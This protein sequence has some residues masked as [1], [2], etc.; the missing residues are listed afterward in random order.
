MSEQPYYIDLE[1]VRRAF[2]L[3]SDAPALLIDFASWLNGRPWGSVGCFGLLGQFS[4]QAPIVDGSL[5]RNDLALFLRLPEGCA[6]GTWNTT[7]VI[8]FTN[9][10]GT[11]R[12]G[13][14][15]RSSLVIW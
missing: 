3:Q 10:G 9:Q 8:S 4:D 14:G 15:A 5:L 13:R 7:A 1:S 12:A 6:V 11:Q 2:P